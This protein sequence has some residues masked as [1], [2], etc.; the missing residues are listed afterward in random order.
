MIEILNGVFYDPNEPWYKQPQ[1]LIDLAGE[2]MSKPAESKIEETLP[3]G[4][5]RL[6]KATWQEQ[7]E[8]GLFEMTVTIDYL[9]EPDSR[10]WSSRKSHDN[11]SIKKLS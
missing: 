2:V 5:K 10:S 6:K 11:I 3:S 8:I 1:E 9:Y 7:T 4:E